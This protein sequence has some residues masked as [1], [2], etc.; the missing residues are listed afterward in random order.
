MG[1]QAV[2]FYKISLRQ[3]SGRKPCSI[4]LLVTHLSTVLLELPVPV[5]ERA[6]LAYSAA[7]SYVADAPGNGALLARGG[8]LVRLAL[9]AEVHDVVTADGAVVDDNVPGPESHCVPL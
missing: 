4:Y 9:D 8:G 3:T 2:P 6:D 1:P 7:C 5:V